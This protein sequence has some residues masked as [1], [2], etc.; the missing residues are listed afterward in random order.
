[1]Y[2]KYPVP[3]TKVAYKNIHGTDVIK[4]MFVYRDAVIVK[5]EP[6]LVLRGSV[7][8]PETKTLSKKA[9]DL[10]ELSVESRILSTDELYAGKIC[11]ALDRQHPRD[12]FDVHVLLKNEGLN[13][14][15]RKAFIVYLISHPRPMIEILNPRFMD[16]RTV[17][18]TE[19]EG[20]IAESV[21][22]EDLSATRERLV[23]MILSDLTTH[24]KEFIVS[25]KEGT[26]K[27]EL[28]GLEGIEHLP[29]VRW[30]LLNIGKMKP[31]KHKE[32]VRKLRNYL[33]V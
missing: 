12:L 20:L 3:G 4:G 18:E 6:N 15:I 16:I 25:V 22:C 7:Y 26:P 21:A 1:S 29:A 9:Q 31:S 19:F 32:A 10:F 24:E 5:I 17:F 13:D 23:S 11:A 30:K 8:Q 14:E 33:G 28:L 2:M 27:W